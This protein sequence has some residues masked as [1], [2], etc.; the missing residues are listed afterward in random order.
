[1]LDIRDI[2]CY[3]ILMYSNIAKEKECIRWNFMKLSVV[4]LYC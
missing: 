2:V 4:R 1:M 3:N